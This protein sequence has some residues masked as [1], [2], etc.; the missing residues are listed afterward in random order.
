VRAGPTVAGP[1][2][3][4]DGR[5]VLVRR[6]AWDSVDGYDSRHVGTGTHPEPAD[7]DLGDRLGRAGWLVLGIPGAEVVVHPIEGQ[8]ILDVRGPER[9]GEGLRRYVRDRYRAPART[10]MALARR[11]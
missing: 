4:L 6:T 8:G 7:L 2:G 5:C 3:W 10:L 1:T 9:R 11:G